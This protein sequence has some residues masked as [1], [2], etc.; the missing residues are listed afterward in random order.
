MNV[1]DFRAWNLRLEEGQ[2]VQCPSCGG[3]FP[4]AEW[5]ETET[6]CEDCGTHQ[7]CICPKCGDVFDSIKGPQFKIRFPVEGMAEKEAA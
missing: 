4:P 7:G 5:L 1:T 3:W 2:E 6:Y